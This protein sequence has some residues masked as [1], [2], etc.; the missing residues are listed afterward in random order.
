[1]K[2]SG[3]VALKE[4]FILYLQT[5]TFYHPLL[6]QLIKLAEEEDSVKILGTRFPKQ[7]IEKDLELDL[8]DKRLKMRRAH[9]PS[10]ALHTHLGVLG[11]TIANVGSH[12][13]YGSC[14]HPCVSPPK[15]DMQLL[16]S[17]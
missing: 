12:S 4:F 6:T 7:N 15:G 11:A 10:T 1:M 5:V 14:F 9:H 13:S 17:T 8:R 16:Q 3:G 2:N